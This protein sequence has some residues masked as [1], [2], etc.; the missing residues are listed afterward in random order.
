MT[1]R[2]SWK[3]VKKTKKS[4]IIGGLLSPKC[5]ETKISAERE[6]EWAQVNEAYFALENI[7]KNAYLHGRFK[8]ARSIYEKAKDAAQ[9][10]KATEYVANLSANQ[11]LWESL[12]G[13]FVIAR[14]KLSDA[15]KLNRGRDVLSTVPLQLHLSANRRRPKVLQ[16]S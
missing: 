2:P 3:R 16:P 9:K 1:Q 13:N 14:A 12:S 5:K 11:A 15:A 4:F 6:A 8:D 7:A 10:Q